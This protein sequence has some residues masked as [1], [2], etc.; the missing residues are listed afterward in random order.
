VA[1]GAGL[2]RTSLL[3]LALTLVVLVAGES[4]DQWLHRIGRV[5]S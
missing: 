3:V 4:V 5:R 1:V 2:W